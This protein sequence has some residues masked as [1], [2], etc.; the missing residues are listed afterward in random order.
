MTRSGRTPRSGTP[1]PP[2]WVQAAA[3]VGIDFAAGARRHLRGLH[4]ALLGQLRPDG[5]PYANTY[6]QLC[7]LYGTA[8]K[9]AAGRTR[10]V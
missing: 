9:A 4:Y 6:E 2:G 10:R 1:P 3:T 5:E 7:W 8:A